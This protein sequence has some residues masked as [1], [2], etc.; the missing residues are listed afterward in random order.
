LNVRIALLVDYPFSTTL[1]APGTGWTVLTAVDPARPPAACV[2]ALDSTAAHVTSLIDAGARI[3]PDANRVGYPDVVRDTRC[4]VVEGYGAFA[5]DGWPVVHVTSLADSG[6]GTLR[7][8]LEGISTP[9][10]VVFDV[11]GWIT[12]TSYIQPT[13]GSF[14][15]DGSS[16]NVGIKGDGITCGHLSYI[17]FYNLRVRVGVNDH[18]GNSNA[19]SCVDCDHVWLSHCSLSWAT[20]QNVGLQS[21]QDITISDCIIAEGLS[22]AGHPDGEHS[23]GCFWM[24]GSPR[25]TFVRNLVIHNADR[26]P[27]AQCG[28][29]DI[30]NN[31][32][33][34]FDFNW[35]AP[36]SGVTRLN[37]RHNVFIPGA[38]T[39][40]GRVYKYALRGK[41]TADYWPQS[42]FYLNGN[43]CD[44][45]LLLIPDTER[46]PEVLTPFAFADL[47]LLAAEEARAF[48]LANAGAIYPTRDAV[49][50]RLV[51]DV[52]NGT[53]TI[54]DD[55]A[56][57]GGWPEL[58]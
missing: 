29:A 51:A 47:T 39:Q 16:A 58:I 46:A 11:S 23:K 8:A 48:V 3:V 37:Y 15:I 4:P 35:I 6:P 18:P 26:N 36:H 52:T 50:A 28:D 54:V 43:V 31:V 19:I 13:A 24:L 49:D 41:D 25:V 33:Y 55:P 20:D 40:A 10:L 14:F 38:N 12:L 42:A 5:P 57:V 21:C 32:V 22:N 53:G 1:P 9:R 7:A 2:I 17:G 44:G 27:T 45:G 56:Q 34:N 30:S